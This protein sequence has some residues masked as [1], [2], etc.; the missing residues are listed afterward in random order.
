[1]DND[2]ITMFKIHLSKH[3]TLALLGNLGSGRRT[4]SKQ[5]AKR[6][7]NNN[8]ILTIK[9]FN[10]FTLIPTDPQTMLSKIVIVPDLIKPW[11]TNTHTKNILQY[12]QKLHSKAEENNCFIIASFQYNYWD[13]INRQPNSTQLIHRNMLSFFSKPFQVVTEIER[14]REIARKRKNDI[15][16]IVL[17]RICEVNTNVKVFKF[18]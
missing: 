16:D 7:R 17:R 18:R 15:S 6:L 8:P 2:F 10:V 13:N 1:M 11:Y 4:L 9:V 3:K 12:L 5:I 14:L